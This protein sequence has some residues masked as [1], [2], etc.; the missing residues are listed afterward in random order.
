MHVYATIADIRAEGLNEAS[1]D[2]DRAIEVLE[3]AADVIDRVTGQR[4]APRWEEH[5]LNGDASP[6]VS[7]P[8]SAH[9][10]EV[11]SLAVNG[12]VRGAEDFLTRDRFIELL[13]G[14][15]PVGR[16]NVLVQGYF[17]LV[18]ERVKVETTVDGIVSAGADEVT[19]ADASG[20]VAGAAILINR[21]HV[22]I[23]QSVT[24]NVV[25]V[26]PVDRAIADGVEAVSFGL[27][28]KAVRRASL[29]L[30]QRMHAPVA[31]DTAAEG[32]RRSAMVK[33]KT[34]NYEYQ[35]GGTQSTTTSG[36]AGRSGAT[37]GYGDVDAILEQLVVSPSLAWS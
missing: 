8:A 16:G 13:A 17:G 12:T 26:D 30:V 23:A 36:G 1:L 37:T 9:I 14:T 15:F 3:L 27:I 35:L 7:H 32:A 2:D 5:R 29:M 4:F 19:L 22:V 24:G 20:V 18:D 11:S 21:E 31:S 34:D 33:E 10:L 28:P 6:L 25:T